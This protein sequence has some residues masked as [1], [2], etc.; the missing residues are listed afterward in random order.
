MNMRALDC[1]ELDQVVGGQ[2]S[3]TSAN[4]N[5][6]GTTTTTTGSSR[7]VTVGADATIGSDGSIS[8]GRVYVSVAWGDGPSTGGSG[9]GGGRSAPMGG[10][11]GIVSM[12]VI[13]INRPSDGARQTQP[14][15]DLAGLY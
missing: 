8:G 2:S 9:G 5:G 1:L 6:P 7:T 11:S 4:Q 3:A 12:P 14:A 10:G 13:E 15:A